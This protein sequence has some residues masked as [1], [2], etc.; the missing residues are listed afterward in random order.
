MQRPDSL[1]KTQMLGKTEGKRR[2]E[3][4][5]MRQLDG[6]T[7]SKYVSLSKL[8]EKVKDREACS[9]AVHGVTKSWMRLSDW[10][11]IITTNA[12][13]PPL[14]AAQFHGPVFLL[15]FFDFFFF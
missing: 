13:S 10:T 8:R 14:R 12:R 5:R 6:I 11:T 9:A 1:E 2:K 7:N 3:R 15:S 4:K